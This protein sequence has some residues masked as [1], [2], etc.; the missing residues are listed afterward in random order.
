MCSCQA[1]SVRVWA[2]PPGLMC[3]CQASSVLVWAAPPRPELAAGAGSVRDWVSPAAGHKYG[4]LYAAL[5]TKAGTQGCGSRTL[6]ALLTS[7]DVANG[8]KLLHKY[9][10]LHSDLKPHNVLLCSSHTVRCTADAHLVACHAR[11]VCTSYRKLHVCMSCRELH[12]TTDRSRMCT[13][14]TVHLSTSRRLRLAT[15]EACALHPQRTMPDYPGC[16]CMPAVYLSF[17]HMS[18]R[19][20]WQ[21]MHGSFPC[22]TPVVSSQS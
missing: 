3:S 15:P 5:P 6:C 12:H 7:L 9:K 13:A 16:R 1:S 8:M 22:R 17:A 10:I 11:H 20:L 19:A 2:A 4:A 18:A 21:H 14:P